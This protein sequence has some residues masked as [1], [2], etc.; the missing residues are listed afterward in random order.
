MPGSLEFPL[1]GVST[2]SSQLGIILGRLRDDG[3]NS[4]LVRDRGSGCRF[5]GSGGRLC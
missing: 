2:P 3:F 1:G 4:R 5:E